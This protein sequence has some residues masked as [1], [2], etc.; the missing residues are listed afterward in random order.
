MQ[1]SAPCLVVGD[2]AT[3]KQVGPLIKA[4]DDVY[5]HGV[6]GAAANDR[7]FIVMGNPVGPPSRDR[8]LP[9]PYRPR[10]HLRKPD[11][12]ADAANRGPPGWDRD[13]PRRHRAGDRACG[14]SGDG[15]DLLDC[16]REGAPELV[17]DGAGSGGGG[18]RGGGAEVAIHCRQGPA[19][20]VP[21][22]RE[23]A[24]ICTRAWNNSFD[25]TPLPWQLESTAA[26]SCCPACLFNQSSRSGLPQLNEL[27]SNFRSKPTTSTTGLLLHMAKRP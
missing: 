3:G 23:A 9:A 25:P 8:V 16:D 11:P 19:L 1:A 27:R 6:Y 15:A 21:T 18:A 22:Y 17:G 20:V 5:L 13:L 26:R 10:R 14:Q 4:P 2:T 7:T 24:A 12:G